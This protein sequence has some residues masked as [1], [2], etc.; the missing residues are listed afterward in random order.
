MKKGKLLARLAAAV[1]FCCLL[2][3]GC[4]EGAEES[5]QS[6]SVPQQS[7]SVSV[8]QTGSSV[9]AS[10]PGNEEDPEV[11]E[12]TIV[13]GGWTEDRNLEKMAQRFNQEQSRYKVVV[14]KIDNF[15]LELMRKKGPDLIDLTNCPVEEF[16]R[17]GVLEELTPY[18]NNS[19]EV[20]LDDLLEDIK[21]LGTV[22]GKLTS[23][24]LSFSFQGIV[25]EKGHTQNG[26]WTLEDYIALA[27]QYPEIRI[28]E[29]INDPVNLFLNDLAFAAEGYISWKDYTSSFDSDSFINFIEKINAYSRKKYDFVS[30]GTPAERLRRRDYL[31]YRITV[32]PS[33]YM[34][35]Y[36][37]LREMMG[38][39]YE[40]AGF[41][42]V[43]G[44]P[45]YKLFTE[46]HLGI[47]AASEKKEAAWAFLEYLLSE[48]MQDDQLR[49]QSRFPAR[50]DVLEAYFQ[51]L[52]GM[53]NDEEEVRPV[54]NMFTE[55]YQMGRI[56]FT[57]EDRAALMAMLEHMEAAQT[58]FAETTQT[59]IA[60]ELSA[61]FKGDKTAKDA[62]GII[63]SKIRIYLM[64]QQ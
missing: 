18:F 23:L 58:M 29:K 17:K 52:I 3:S 13:I 60:E 49:K 53:K 25:V 26:G 37:Q 31:T 1:L 36:L 28:C 33:S 6:G 12:N 43:T 47:N 55:E 30:S 57:E 56:P 22:D 7:S 62:A 4:G 20:Q 59:I 11:D 5:K 10:Q 35:N 21:R 50:K 45:R 19:S 41:P 61:Y 9:P 44:E 14:R 8:P 42:G 2:L 40:L 54:L 15:V 51:E 16:A 27:E 48:G 32:Y 63:Q 39:E 24:I 46:Y 34:Q 38:E 64:E